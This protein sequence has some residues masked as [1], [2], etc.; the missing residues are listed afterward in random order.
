MTTFAILGYLFEPYIK[1]IVLLL[2]IYLSLFKMNNYILNLIIKYIY[3]NEPLTIN[4]FIITI[5]NTLSSMVTAVIFMF[6]LIVYK[7]FSKLKIK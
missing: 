4:E 7:P 6:I 2:G 3:I 5:I 1:I